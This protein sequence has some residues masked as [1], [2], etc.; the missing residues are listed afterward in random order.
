MSKKKNTYNATEVTANSLIPGN[1][2]L[3]N[4]GSLAVVT[5]VKRVTQ[6]ITRP[7]HVNVVE[8][9]I[10]EGDAKGANQWQ[11]MF[12]TTAVS[13]VRTPEDRRRARK[14]MWDAM[15]ERFFGTK[16]PL[17]NTEE[18][19]AQMPHFMDRYPYGPS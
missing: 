10:V 4:D 5:D 9:E 15:K 1:H 14:D 12:N 8:Y 3:L 18:T 19:P 13:L 17:K 11:P 2:I 6:H 16:K 7:V